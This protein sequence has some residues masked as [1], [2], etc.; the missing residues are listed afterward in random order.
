M[1]EIQYCL[2]GVDWWPLCMS[3]ADWAS[4]TQAI[5]SVLAILAAVAIAAKQAKRARFDRIDDQAARYA[6]VYAPALALGDEAHRVLQYLYDSVFSDAAPLPGYGAG[7]HVWQESQELQNRVAELNPAA[8]P[9]AVGITAVHR[10][11]R[12]VATATEQLHDLASRSL[13]TEP[14]D[15][16]REA[17]FLQ[18]LAEIRGCLATLRGDLVR[19]SH[20]GD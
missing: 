15:N 14:R 10:L 7:A 13:R 1:T 19:V 16:E 18:S 8:L 3:R 9:S 2:L 17:M 4:W 5:G 6:A 11:Q 20:P 12:T